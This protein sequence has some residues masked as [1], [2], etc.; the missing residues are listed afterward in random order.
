[1]PAT[2]S[3]KYSLTLALLALGPALGL[4][5]F[6]PKSSSAQPQGSYAFPIQVTSVEV[7]ATGPGQLIADVEG[8]IPNGCSR[9]EQVV[10]WRE[11]DQIVVRLLAR[12]SGAEVCT[13]IAQLYRDSTPID[14]PLPAGDY[15]LDV[16]GL[17]RTLHVD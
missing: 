2:S 9:F 13:M 10:Q 5:A 16:N 11:A 17:A 14:G 1:M 12:N 4:A 7:R 15:L 6:G 3:V 8:V